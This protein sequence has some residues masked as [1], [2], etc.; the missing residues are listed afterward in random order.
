VP[1]IGQRRRLYQ[2]YIPRSKYAH[3]HLSRAS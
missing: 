1:D 2:P 3:V